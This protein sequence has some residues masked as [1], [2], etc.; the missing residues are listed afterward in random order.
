MSKVIEMIED[1]ADFQI[2]NIVEVSDV[3]ANRLIS[4]GKAKKYDLKSAIEKS[5]T[6]IISKEVN[7]KSDIIAFSFNL[8][9]S[10]ENFILTNSEVLLTTAI[11]F[12][13][14]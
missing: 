1:F 4:E 5:Q 14:I 2:G 12:F 11:F 6:K 13:S 3:Y 9:I 7:L 10:H 8:K